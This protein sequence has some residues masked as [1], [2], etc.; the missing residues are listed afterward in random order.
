MRRL[1]RSSVTQL[2]SSWRTSGADEECGRGYR[3]TIPLQQLP[4]TM[5]CGPSSS[6]GNCFDTRRNIETEQ[7]PCFFP[8]E[9]DAFPFRKS[10]NPAFAT[11]HPTRMNKYL[12]PAIRCKRRLKLR[13]PGHDHLVEPHAY[14]LDRCGIPVLLCYELAMDGTPG[15]AEGWSELE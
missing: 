14:G 1:P 4:S 5:V 2:L 15:S 11:F 9:G 12:L 3:I 6:P 8:G 10:S 13:Y 7:E